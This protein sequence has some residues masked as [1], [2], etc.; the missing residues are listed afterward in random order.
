MSIRTSSWSAGMPCWADLT[1]PDVAT[2]RRFYS[3]VLGWVFQATGEEYGGYEIAQVHGAAAAGIGPLPQEGMPSA[4]ALYLAS[5]DVEKTSA[6][7][8]EHGGALLLAPGDVGPLGRM[9]IA[10][11]PTGAVFGVW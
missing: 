9:C 5:D 8:V 10:A 2:A 6:G 7:I 11:D 4:W 1:V 3:A